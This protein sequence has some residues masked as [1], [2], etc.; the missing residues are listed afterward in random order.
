MF[1]ERGLKIDSTNINFLQL[2]AN[3]QYFEKE[4]EEAI[5]TLK[6]LEDLQF[7]SVNTYEMYGMSYFNLEQIDSAE[8][9]FK[10]AL[11]LDRQ[12]PKILYRLGTIEFARK[13]FRKA[14]FYTN[15]AIIY[16]KPDLDKQYMLMGI[17]AKEEL[18]LKMA[19]NYFE[20]AYTNN[21]SNLDALFELAFASDGYYKDK[22]IALQY[23]ERFVERISDKSPKLKTFATDRIKE[24]RKKFFIDGVIVD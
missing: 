20:K 10:K 7:K 11:R 15:Q 12:N 21:R 19:I 17:M 4:F 24:I 2:K 13:D 16:S 18:D 1:I 23:Y 14:R 22:K 6:K 5:V 3:D 9:Y 8:V